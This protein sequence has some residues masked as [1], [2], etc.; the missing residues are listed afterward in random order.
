MRRHATHRSKQR[1]WLQHKGVYATTTTLRKAK[2]GVPLD[3][4][5]AATRRASLQN[6]K[7]KPLDLL[8]ISKPVL[9]K[10]SEQKTV[11]DDSNQKTGEIEAKNKR[12]HRSSDVHGSGNEYG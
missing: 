2:C 11:E 6:V 5:K 8:I 1:D 4:G 9:E 3:Y 7:T 12:R 10:R